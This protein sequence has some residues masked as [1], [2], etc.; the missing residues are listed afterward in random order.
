[1][2]RGGL[3]P[4]VLNAA[5]EAAV[6]LFLGERIGF[7]DIERLVREALDADYGAYPLTVDGIFALD[8][9]VKRRIRERF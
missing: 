2:K 1:M 8:T 7:L 6:A 3:I 9:E 4:T 5:N